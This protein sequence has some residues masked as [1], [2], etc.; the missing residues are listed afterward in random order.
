MTKQ[1][2]NVPLSTSS[3]SEVADFMELQCLMSPNKSYSAVDA[4][5]AMGMLNEEEI[6]DSIED[7]RKL[8]NTYEALSEI[9]DRFRLCNRRYPFITTAYSIELNANVEKNV[10]DLYTFLLFATR[11]NMKQVRRLSD[12]LDATQIFEQLCSLVAKN[13]FGN[14]SRSFVFGTGGDIHSFK[15][16]VDDF[17]SRL[18]EKGYRHRMVEDHL[19]TDKDGKVDV[20][21]HIPFPED[22]R[23]GSLIAIGQ[24]KTGTNWRMSLGTTNGQVFSDS[25]F[26]RL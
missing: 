20:I 25:M 6:D 1:I 2:G 21:V 22:E 9:E 18:S 10:V 3:R 17:L 16:K 26:I 24:C 11:S 4:A 14:N 12:G 23:K 19:N 7:E 13:Y 8:G 15:Q 5:L